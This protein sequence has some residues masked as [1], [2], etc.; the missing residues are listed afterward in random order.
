MAMRVFT[1]VS[2]AAFSDLAF[3]YTSAK[4]DRFPEM[5]FSDSK[6]AA[7]VVERLLI[8]PLT[9]WP[10]E[11]LRLLGHALGAELVHFRAALIMSLTPSDWGLF[12]DPADA[13]YG[14]VFREVFEPKGFRLDT[15]AIQ[16]IEFDTTP[17]ESLIDEPLE[18]PGV[19]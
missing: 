9:R 18:R 16:Q 17:V 19:G 7:D 1:S 6:E 5:R 4:S 14:Q 2:G 15:Y 13:F 11:A 12:S 10:D 3:D 8:E